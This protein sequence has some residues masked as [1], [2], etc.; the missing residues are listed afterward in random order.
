[1]DEWKEIKV[2]TPQFELH[3]EIEQKHWWFTGRRKIMRSV[4]E[5]LVPPDRKSVVLDVGCGTGGNIASL[6]DGYR[7]IGIDTSEAAISLA[8]QRFPDVEFLCGRAPQEL[9]EQMKDV[10][11]VLLMDVLEHVPDD[12]L[13][14][15]ELLDSVKPGTWFLMT[16]P[17]DLQLWSEHDVHFGHYRRYDLPRFEEIWSGQPVE[18]RLVSYCNTRLYPIV[19]S[20]RARNRRRGTTSGKS[21]TDLHVPMAPMNWALDRVFSGESRRLGRALHSR[22]RTSSTAGVSL[23]AAVQRKEGSVEIRHKSSEMIDHYDPVAGVY[24]S[25]QSAAV[26]IS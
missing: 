9:G 22:H 10:Q 14:F 26:A 7:T 3:A 25:E 20:I 24:L 13:M 1:M 19:K 16:V 2:D 23:I 17:A 18:C 15:S 6:A 12:L 4:I 21:G 11:V 8:K 5:Q